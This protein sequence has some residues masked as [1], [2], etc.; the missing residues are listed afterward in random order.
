MK[1]INY[2][3]GILL[4]LGVICFLAWSWWAVALGV[5]INDI[6]KHLPSFPAL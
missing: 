3:L 6:A 4:G 2:I 5:I 1:R